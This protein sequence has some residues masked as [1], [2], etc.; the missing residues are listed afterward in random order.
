M[1]VDVCAIRRFCADKKNIRRAARQSWGMS[2]EERIVIYVGRLEA[3]KGV[4]VLLSAFARA[5]QGEN[6]L[7]LAI[8][9][10][11]SL[12]PRV[13]ALAARPDK[14]IIY[15]GRLCGNDVL[16][17]Y[18]AADVLVLP[19]LS[20]SWGLVINEAMACGLPVVVSDRV[21]CIEDLVRPGETGLVVGA[22]GE[23]ELSAAIMWLLRD[24]CARSRMGRAAEMLISNWT[25]ARE[26][27]NVVSAWN[28]IAR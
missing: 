2:A 20:E 9:G 11:G 25:L 5:I 28:E 21:G 6:D 19:S 26:A 24:S 10:D 7:R 12:R 14:R 22:D 1:T 16:R 17:A 4:N 8:V 27:Q 3:Y 13:E 15:L 23:S 18:V